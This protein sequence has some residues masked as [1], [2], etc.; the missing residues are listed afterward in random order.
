[1]IEELGVEV[2]CLAVD[3][4]QASDDWD[5]VRERRPA[6]GASIA[7]WST[8]ERSSP[9]TSWPRPQ[10][11]RPLR[12]PYPLVSALS[13]PVIV[14]HLVEARPLPRRRRRGPRL[15]RQGQ[16]PGALRGV[17]RALAP[18][19]EVIAPVRGWGMT[20]EDSIHYAY[21]PRH[22]DPGHEGE[23]VLDR[24]QPL[25]PGHRVRRDGGSVGRAAQVGVW[26]LTKQTATEPRDL[27]IGFEQ[28]VPV[29]STARSWACS[30]S[31]IG[32]TPSWAPTAGAASTWSRT[33]GSASRAAR[34]TSARPPWR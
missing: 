1:M 26:L 24:R 30:R 34:P 28:G 14:K 4:G 18:D 21:R 29:A 17:T 33:A 2:V 10:G 13:R 16:R 20:R 11:Q 32:S 7:S 15:H 5:V 12:G 8:P 23:G 31:S 9:T 6:A 27:V 3:V 22:P 25:G 19:L